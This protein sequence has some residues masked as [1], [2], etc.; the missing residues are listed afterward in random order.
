MLPTLVLGAALTGT[1][2][3]AHG[4]VSAGVPLYCGGD[5]G[6]SVALTFDD[7]PAATTPRVLRT[8]ERVH[9]RAT[10][11]VVGAKIAGHTSLIRRAAAL[12]EVGNHSWSHSNLSKQSAHDVFTELARTQRA[13]RR[14][15]APTP[16]VFRPP[17]GKRNVT[18]D[19]GARSL[20]LLEI[21][22]SVDSLDWRG[23]SSTQIARTVLTLV[24]P[25]SIVLLHDVIPRTAA[26]LPRILRNLKA[27]GLNLVTVSELL[28]RDPPTSAQVDL[29]PR[30]CS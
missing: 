20:D 1:A 4:D 14:A 18:V 13:V 29:G 10:F 19:A 26:A 8:L 30:G 17:F 11:F 21:R 24:R 15:G 28:K 2:A 22:S 23:A 7:G 9:A 6:R 16:A 27:R 3:T 12:G 5:T 25:G